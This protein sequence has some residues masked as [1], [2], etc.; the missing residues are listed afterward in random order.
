M[1][2]SFLFERIVRRSPEGLPPNTRGKIADSLPHRLAVEHGPI[3]PIGMVA[4]RF[5]D[6]SGGED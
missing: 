6:L 3:G 2:Q 5:S 1:G 4:R